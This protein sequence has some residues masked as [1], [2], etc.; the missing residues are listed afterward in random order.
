MNRYRQET[1]ALPRE[2]EI[3]I[4]TELTNR[5]RA[6]PHGQVAAA[7][8]PMTLEQFRL[9]VNGCRPFDDICLTIGLYGESLGHADLIAMIAAAKEAG[10]LGINIETDGRAL[11]GE[12]TR[13]LIEAPVDVISVHFDTPAAKGY[14]EFIERGDYEQ[15]EKQLKEFL[16]LRGADSGTPLL[17]PHMVKTLQTM[18]D[19]EEFYDRWKRDADAAVIEGYNTYAG[20]VED[21]SVMDMCPPQRFPCRRLSRTM[22]IFADGTVGCVQDFQVGTPLGNA[23]EQTLTEIWQSESLENLRRAHWEENYDLHPLCSA[24]REWHR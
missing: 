13:E 15:L 11:Q 17:I 14:H 19:M 3:E 2:I 12:L 6:Y 18:G 20:Q 5:L 22:T 10:I 7:R 4:N 1:E 8:S 24:C 9:I 23:F 21:Y 16:E